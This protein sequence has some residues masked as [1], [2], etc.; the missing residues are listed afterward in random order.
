MAGGPGCFY[1]QINKQAK[2]HATRDSPLNTPRAGRGPRI[3][4]AYDDFA[5]ETVAAADRRLGYESPVEWA[6]ESLKE[7]YLRMKRTSLWYAPQ[8]I[9]RV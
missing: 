7:M 6:P 4:D 2:Y 1:A 5:W 3:T 8:D 9:Q